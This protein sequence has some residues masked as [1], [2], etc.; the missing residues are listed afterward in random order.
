M[1]YRRHRRSSSR[2]ESPERSS[3]SR[4]KASIEPRDDATAG[5]GDATSSSG[6]HHRSSSS[7][8]HHR[9]H[10]SQ[11]HSEG[12]PRRRRER[13]E[14][15]KLILRAQRQFVGAILMTV[16]LCLSRG[17]QLVSAMLLGPRAQPVEERP[18]EQPSGSGDPVPSAAPSTSTTVATRS[19]GQAS[20]YRMTNDGFTPNQNR[21]I[22]PPEDLD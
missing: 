5:G 6:T 16:G 10:R 21:A 13:P 20:N 22:V 15:L 3:G 19:Y 2:D 9:S 7:R 14:W 11:Q 8:H 18:R 4:S 12:R 17:A 1:G